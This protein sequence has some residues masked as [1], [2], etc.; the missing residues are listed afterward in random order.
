V[1]ELDGKKEL[2]L[3]SL[4]W[5]KS[6]TEDVQAA[7]APVPASSPARI[8][9]LNVIGRLIPIPYQTHPYGSNRADFAASRET[10]QI[11]VDGPRPARHAFLTHRP[12]SSACQ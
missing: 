4:N 7:S 1:S 10:R 8:T 9:L 3:G 12:F 5:E 11:L 6:G 2:G